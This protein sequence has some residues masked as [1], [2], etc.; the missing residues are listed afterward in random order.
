MPLSGYIIEGRAHLLARIK[1]VF[2]LLLAAGL[3]VSGAPMITLLAPAADVALLLLC[4]RVVK[5]S[6]ALAVFVM[7]TTWA[8]LLALAPL[9]LGVRGLA[10]W[11]LFVLMPASAGFVLGRRALL[12]Q[13]A[14]MTA[15]ILAFG[16]FLLFQAN[17]PLLFD[18][19][20]LGLL[21]GA[22]LAS[23]L[24]LAWLME[25][26]LRA[27]S[28]SRDMLGQPIV[29]VR[30]VLVTPLNW[31]VGGVQV[32]RLREELNELKRQHNPRWVVL[33]LAPAGPIGRHDLHAVERAAE[34]AGN[35]SCPVVLA[36][37]PVDAIGHLD[38]AQPAVGRV[39]R[40]ATVAQAVE[41]GLRRL[42]WTTGSEQGQRVMTT[43]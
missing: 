14:V 1:L 30:G 42:G 27:E 13:M 12:W 36:R 31:A 10:L 26:V 20:A 23:T 41:A 25:R 39:E 5:R 16:L 8:G 9:A 33:D 35:R 18:G 21:A 11:P 3:Y 40:F 22:T 17:Q 19:I 38:L 34:E 29:V 7:L 6:P 32:D 2:D 28:G 43:Y 37:P 4:L 24:L 15:G